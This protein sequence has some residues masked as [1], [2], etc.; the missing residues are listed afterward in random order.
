MIYSFS[1]LWLSHQ[2][3]V[4]FN[5]IMISPLLPSCL[6]LDVGYLF[7]ALSNIFFFFFF[8]D[9]CLSVSSSFRVFFFFLRKDELIFF[10]FAILQAKTSYNLIV[11]SEKLF[12]LPSSLPS[13]I[14]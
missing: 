11:K 14:Q 7:L 2:L 3:G 5:F 1:S 9:G 6:S 4:G 8:V 13:H 10:Y 12:F